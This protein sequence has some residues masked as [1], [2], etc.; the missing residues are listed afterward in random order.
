MKPALAS[1]LLII[2][3]ISLS[4]PLNAQ[5]AKIWHWDYKDALNEAEEEGKHLLLLFGN[6]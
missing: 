6:G 4:A 3:I 1:S 5:D 2:C